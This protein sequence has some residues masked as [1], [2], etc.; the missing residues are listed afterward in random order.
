MDREL[1]VA[2]VEIAHFA[3]LAFAAPTVSRVGPPFIAVKSTR[4][5]KVASSGRAE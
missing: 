4:S 2:A 1:R 3:G 5:D